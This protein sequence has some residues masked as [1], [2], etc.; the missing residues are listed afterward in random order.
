MKARQTWILIA[1]H[2]SLVAAG[3][4]KEPADTLELRGIVTDIRTGLGIPD[5][6]VTLEEQVVESGVWVGT[7][8]EAGE[9]TT[10]AAGLYEIGFGRKNA[11]A[12]QTRASKP[13]WFPQ[14]QDLSADNWRGETTSEWSV[15]LVPKGWVTLSFV[16]SQPFSDPEGTQVDF[17]F[18]HT[19]PL[20][21]P[22]CSNDWIHFGGNSEPPPGICLLE[23]DRFLPYTIEVERDGNLSVWVDSVYISR[24]DTIPL[25]ILY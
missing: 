10:D 5:V 6:A 21:L 18:L 7:W 12:Y 13:L 22:V 3:C 25:Q 24:F 9:T 19:N 17:R 23:G 15:S 11:L 16:N 14:K 2:L 20:N 1:L 8:N 4:R